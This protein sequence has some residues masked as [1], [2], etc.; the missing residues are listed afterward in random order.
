MATPSVITTTSSIP[1][2]PAGEPWRQVYLRS[3]RY[4]GSGGTRGPTRSCSTVDGGATSCR[5]AGRI[6]TVLEDR[7]SER[8][9]PLL[10]ET[11]PDSVATP[12]IPDSPFNKTSYPD[13]RSSA[14]TGSRVHHPAS[15]FRRGQRESAGVLN[16]FGETVSFGGATTVSGDGLVFDR[17]RP[18]SSADQGGPRSSTSMAGCG[19]YQKSLRRLKS[20]PSSK[21]RRATVADRHQRRRTAGP[22][23]P[24]R[25]RT[26]P[27][28]HTGAA[29]RSELRHEV[30]L[31][32]LSEIGRRTARRSR[33]GSRLRLWSERAP[34][35]SRSRGRAAPP[36][37]AT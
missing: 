5:R 16:G 33:W 32:T 14:R 9:C 6:Q 21:T 15:I 4:T 30:A 19:R 34:W 23:L 17:P 7:L 27:S 20:G 13:H 37:S 22:G 18:P 24:G 10:T 31:P 35:T 1:M 36:T 2:A 8:R 28:P 29:D 3:I 25:G 11:N 26:S 12:H